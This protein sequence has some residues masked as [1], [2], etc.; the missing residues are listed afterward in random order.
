MANVVDKPEREGGTVS[1]PEQ[2]TG[3]LPGAS[4]VLG[5]PGLHFLGHLGVWSVACT[6]T[7]GVRM[8][9]SGAGRDQG[10]LGLSA[11]CPFCVVLGDEG[12]RE[13]DV[14]STAE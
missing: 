11:L 7:P 8:G 9:C 2:P 5:T 3:L 12:R 10:Q 4:W 14:H 6:R 13:C 1:R